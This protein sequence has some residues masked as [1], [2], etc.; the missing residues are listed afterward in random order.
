VNRNKE[1]WMKLCE[2]ASKEQDPKKLSEL[3]EE[4]NRILDEKQRRIN[5]TTAA[6][7]DRLV[8]HFG[9]SLFPH[10]A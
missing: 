1:R 3:V 2:L 8:A 5:G 10:A 7:H 4:I 6:F 9:A